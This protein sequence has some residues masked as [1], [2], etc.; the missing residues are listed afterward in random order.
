ML[1]LAGTSLGGI[2]AVIG[3]A[4]EPEIMTVTPIVAGA[5][6]ADVMTRSGLHFI[7]EP[8]FEQ[9]LGNLVVGCSIEGELH[10]SQG[11]DAD[12]CRKAAETSFLKVAAQP[13]GTTVRLVNLANGVEAN[14]T[15][16]EDGGFALAVDTDIGDQLEIHIATP[17]EL[18][19]K[20]QFSAKF[21]GSGYQR[22]TAE[23]RR[24]VTVQQHGFDM[25]DPVNFAGH[26]FKA[27]LPGHKPTNTL[28][29]N[30]IGDDTV[31]VA[32]S[33]ALGLAAGVFG[34]EEDDWRGATEWLIDRGVLLNSLYDVHDILD[35]NPE[36][37][38]PYGLY[39]PIPTATG[40]SSI[41]FADVNGKHEWI[42]GYQKDDFEFG[43]YSQ[44][45]IAVFHACGGRLILD[46]P[47]DCLQT[48]DC[49]LLDSLESIDGCEHVGLSNR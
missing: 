4:M 2:H 31:P 29:M 25:C 47:V 38:P 14:T 39:A 21:E 49:S 26:L 3:A 6:L 44:N 22:N 19:A 16:N 37:Q 40:V 9:I 42:A 24:A 34:L 8:L 41:R 5:G 12:R 18:I 36:E 30:A 11:N 1:S 7:L 43:R 17:D 23:F 13:A 15:I 10:I 28:F 35:N 33:V 45:Q 27:P 20:E 48:L 46:T 32:T